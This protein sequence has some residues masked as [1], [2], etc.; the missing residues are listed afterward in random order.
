[1]ATDPVCGMYVEE[2]PDAL[3]LTR[4][5]RT[6]YFCAPSCLASFAEPEAERRRLRRRLAV[7]WPLSVAVVVLAYAGPSRTDAFLAAA[8]ALVVQGYAG[9]PF[10]RGAWEALR[11]RIGNMD[12][13]IAVGTTAA[14]GESLAALLLPG[15]LPAVYYFDAAAMIVTLIL[16]GSYLEHL[17]RVRAGSALA[18]LADSLPT[19]AAVV[20]PE[21]DRTVPVAELAPG[22]V[23]RVAPGARYP[24]DGV[25][26]AGRTSADESILTGEP[27]PVPKSPGDAVLA[28]AWNREGAVEVEVRRVGGDAFVGQVAALLGE[29]EM[30]RVPLQRTADRI[31]AAF[32]PLVLALALGAA[33]GWATLGRAPLSVSILIFVTVAITACPC[34][35]GL[36]TPAAILV[37]TGRAAEDGILFRGGDAIARTAQVDR[38]LLDKTG[39][40]TA[41]TPSVAT[42]SPCA[43]ASGPE[44]LGLAAG[45]STGVDHPLATSVR[46][47]AAEERCAPVPF[48]E[49]TVDPGRGVRGRSGGR[50][51]AFL[52]V[53]TA[54]GEG[55]DLAPLAAWWAR[56]TAAGESG[57]VVLVDGRPVGGIS[58]RA[59]LSPGAPA[60]IASL[61]ALGVD[62][63]MVT[64]D[65]PAPARA[66][67]DAVGIAVVHA[68]VD[69]AGKVAVVDA[70]R[71]TG[72]RVAFVG[73]GINDA[74]ALAAADV[75]M[76]IGSGTDVAREAGQVLLVRSDLRGVP[77]AI[78]LA[79]R[80]VARVGENLRWAIGYNAVLLPVAGGLLVPWLG[81]GVYRWLPIAG[82]LA[83]GLSSTTVVWNSLS[84]RRAA[85]PGMP[86]GAL[87]PVAAPGSGG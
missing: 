60:A 77:A 39:T 27:L 10:Y 58:F 52:S 50:S 30:A 34:A 75:G 21:G 18:R 13:L 48:D 26:R 22:T 24:V 80:T 72:H 38:V 57:S 83:M 53:E 87:A 73:D 6:Y 62:V 19:T 42:I 28:G 55:A 63:E 12:L 76:A 1:M 67:A 46:R 45:L 79:R 35:F 4:E 9:S 51:V 14:Y 66:V 3:R 15:R 25:V 31:A 64:G 7:A 78:A 41:A 32:V 11:R 85:A 8:L 23:V 16:T 5:N 81:F 20:G 33:V 82:A 68:G 43:G 84:L 59:D 74:A 44:V 69:P 40:L 17:T 61:R 29:A 65:A 47:R 54:R 49:R 2:G 71:R 70:A 36:A 37:A 56:V 86:A